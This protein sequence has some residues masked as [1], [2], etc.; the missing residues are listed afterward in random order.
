MKIALDVMSGDYAPQSTIGGAVAFVQEIKD[1]EV[2]LVGKQEIIEEELKKY[3]Q[4]S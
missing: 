2:I 4:E 3:K 1:T